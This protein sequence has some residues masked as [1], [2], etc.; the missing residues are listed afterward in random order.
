M[1]AELDLADK[2]NAY[3]ATLSQ[4]QKQRVCIARA[5]INKPALILADEPT[6]SLDDV[7]AEKCSQITH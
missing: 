3:P 1:L 4:G 5:V 6:S 2:A 7:R